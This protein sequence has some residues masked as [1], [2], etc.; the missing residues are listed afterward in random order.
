VTEIRNNHSRA[1]INGSHQN[2]LRLQISVYKILVMKILYSLEN[3]PNDCCSRGAS[4]TSTAIFEV[5]EKVTCCDQLLKDVADNNRKRAL[6]Q[7][8]EACIHM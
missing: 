3:L 7:N 5:R 8:L 2:V 4:E 1:L 6:K